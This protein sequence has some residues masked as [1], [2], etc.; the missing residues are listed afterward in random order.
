MNGSESK[1]KFIS[2]VHN[3]HGLDSKLEVDDQKWHASCLTISHDQYKDELRKCI[4]HFKIAINLSNHMNQVYIV[5]MGNG[6][7][8]KS[9]SEISIFIVMLKC[10]VTWKVILKITQIF[11]VH[12]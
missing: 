12:T 3:I 10:I 4:R 1:W 9:A 8:N 11:M 5:L 2:N 7:L 6:L